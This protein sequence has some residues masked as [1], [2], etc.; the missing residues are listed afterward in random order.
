MRVHMRI[1]RC[2]QVARTVERGEAHP[3]PGERVRATLLPVDDAH[4]MPDDEAGCANGLHRVTK[5]AARRD[6]VLDE[7]HELTW[8]VR[9]LEAVPGAV[10]L[11]F[12]AHDDEGQLRTPWQ[13]KRPARPL[14]AP[15]RRA[16]R[17]RARPPP[18]AAARRSPSS[19]SRLG[20][21]SKRYLSRYQRDRLP[22][23]S[24]KSPSSSAT[25]RSRRPS[26]STSLTAAPAGDRDEPL[27]LLASPR[28]ARARSR[29]PTRRPRDRSVPRPPSEE[30]PERE[31][32]RGEQD[33]LHAVASRSRRSVARRSNATRPT[34]GSAI[35][36]ATIE[37]S[38]SRTTT[39][40]PR[41]T[42]DVH[43]LDARRRRER[44][45]RRGREQTPRPRSQAPAPARRSPPARPRPAVRRDDDRL[46]DLR[47]ELEKL[48][49]SGRGVHAGA[50]N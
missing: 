35:V 43:P 30:E 46:D 39:S 16:A 38:P 36:V 4:R 22:E 1:P 50:R 8:L 6:D 20:S 17:P 32:R 31:T 13:L 49:E 21:V 47:R 45:G 33:Q 19:R 15:G 37:R 3:E 23:R 29:R 2:Q 34:V 24:V 7:A 25:S 12:I 40:E 42:I 5:G 44:I 10:S 41:S 48:R 11:G 26:S 14:R 28:G 9:P 27:A 18:A